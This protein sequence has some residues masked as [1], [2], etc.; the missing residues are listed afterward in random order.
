MIWPETVSPCD[1]A[2]SFHSLPEIDFIVSFLESVVDALLF[3]LIGHRAFGDPLASFVRSSREAERCPP[4][5][6]N[7]VSFPIEKRHLSAGRANE[8]SLGEVRFFAKM[9]PSFCAL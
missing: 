4:F 7:R 9:S 6:Q 8:P 5:S 2:F 3:F 1:T